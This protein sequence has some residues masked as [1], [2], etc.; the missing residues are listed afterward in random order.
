VGGSAFGGVDWRKKK[1]SATLTS[2]L[3]PSGKGGGGGLVQL[4]KGKSGFSGGKTLKEI[5]QSH[6]KVRPSIFLRKGGA[7]RRLGKRS[8]ATDRGKKGPFQKSRGQSKNKTQDA[9]G[10]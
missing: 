6:Q 10:C 7:E 5:W 4:E 2:E 8:K 3:A 1:T 9:P